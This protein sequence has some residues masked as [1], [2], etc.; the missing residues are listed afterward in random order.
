MTVRITD[1]Y[2]RYATR[3]ITSGRRVSM[4]GVRKCT[5]CTALYRTDDTGLTVCPD[6]RPDHDRI[7]TQCGIHFTGERD[8]IRLCKCCRN[9][10]P[11]F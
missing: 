10:A 11:L 2:F 4:P 1:E 9:Q 3:Q 7:C 5:D 8:G 6:C